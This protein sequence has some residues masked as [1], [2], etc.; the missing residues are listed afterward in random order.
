MSKAVRILNNVRLALFPAAY[1]LTG[2]LVLG[3]LNRIFTD[4]LGI[5]LALVGLVLAVPWIISPLRVW[6]GYRSDGFRIL[7]LR[8]EPYII[9]GAALFGLAVLVTSAAVVVLSHATA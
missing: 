1:G 3:V 2:A 5:S 9:I 8:R 6:L 7:G 4:E